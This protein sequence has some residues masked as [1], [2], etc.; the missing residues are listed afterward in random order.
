[1]IP[2]VCNYGISHVQFLNDFETKLISDFPQSVLRQS[3]L[4]QPPLG[5][6]FILHSSF[7]D[8]RTCNKVLPYIDCYN[9]ENL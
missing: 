4:A 5:P 2:L 8:R 9:L 1:M 6:R 7:A 3:Q